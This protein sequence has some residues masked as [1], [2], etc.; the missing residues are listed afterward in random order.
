MKINKERFKKEL[1]KR[2]ETDYGKHLDEAHDFEVYNALAK[3]V[4]GEIRKDWRETRSL[5]AETKKAYY[6]SAE[7][8]M[9]RALGNNLI[10]LQIQEEVKEILDEIGFD[11]NK[12]EDVESDAGLGNGG[13]G[14]LAACFLDSLVTLNLPGYGYGIRYKD[15]M[16]KQNIENG[17]QVEYPDS[18]LKY[19]DPWSIRRLDRAVTV[20]FGKEKVR[21][22]PYDTPIIGYGTNNINTLRLWQAE[23]IESFDMKEFNAQ[24]YALALEGQ[25]K[26]ENISRVLYPN[27]DTDEGKKLRLRQQYFFTSASLQDIVR[28]YKKENGEDF[29]GFAEKVSIQLN[30]THPTVAIP[31]LMRILTE[32]EGLSWKEAWAIS[33]KTFS[34]TNHTI[35]SEALE[36]WWSGLFREV[37]PNIYAIVDRIHFQLLDELQEKFPGDY[38]K[39]RKLEI[40]DR[41]SGLIRMAW[42]AIYSSHTTNGVAALHTE[43]LKN[44]ELKDWYEIYP[45]RFQNKTN[46]ITQRRWLLKSNPELASLITELIG[47]EWVTDLSKLKGLEKYQDDEKVLNKFLDIKQLNKEKLAKIIKEI[48]GVEVDTNSLFDVQV[49]RLHEYKRQ[50][51]NV[52]HIMDLYNQIKENPSMEVTPRTFIFGAKAAAGY[53]RAKAVIKL[54]NEV[55]KKV[56]SDEDVAGRIKVVF[57]R[58]YRVSV[59]ER[60]FPASDLSEQISTAGKEASGTGNMKFMLNGAPTIGTLDGA[61][62]EIVE[63]AG[64]ENNFIFGAKVEEIEDLKANGYDFMKY[65]HETPGLKRVVDQLVD[66]TYH[67]DFTGM[68]RELHDSLIYGREWHSADEYFVL[69][70][71]ADYRKAQLEVSKAYKDRLGWAKKAWLN[72][73][74]AGKF[75]S[76]RTISQYAEEIWGIKP[77]VLEKESTEGVIDSLNT[78]LAK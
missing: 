72:I 14:R 42:L 62:V 1:I 18:W 13:L 24:R 26:S 28:R 46:G 19:G 38:E 39:H 27:D 12:V 70:D 57:I 67:D 10:N 75:T 8:L 15:G 30:D 22:V 69:R 41:E 50:F 58:N 47:D 71:F 74:N 20:T 7:Y 32:E 53:F 29:E 76:D 45:E 68:F 59:A 66:G 23:A 31:E 61:N 35:L 48:E 5:Y 44:Q 17:H 21:A 37:I 36:K 54:I 60:I 25:V 4:L 52:L 55:A 78:L 43:I 3:V 33:S 6:L 2:V 65:Y 9:G 73:A 56:N 49:K 34:Y 11:I 77:T 16:F 40:I 64:V 51:L 63:E